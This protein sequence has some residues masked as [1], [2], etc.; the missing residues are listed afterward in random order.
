EGVAQS[1]LEKESALLEFKKV[2]LS[3]HLIKTTGR[4]RD[5]LLAEFISNPASLVE[6]LA[7]EKIVFREKDVENTLLGLV[8]ESE[9]CYRVLESYGEGRQYP[10]DIEIANQ[11]VNFAHD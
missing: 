3:N 9:A 10:K 4:E 7:K 1:Y 5:V 8:S 6:V 11:T 2:G